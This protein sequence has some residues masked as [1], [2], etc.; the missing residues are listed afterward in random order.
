MNG[1]ATANGTI[2]GASASSHGSGD[3]HFV[4]GAGTVSYDGY[5]NGYR[6]TLFEAGLTSTSIDA[7]TSA[8]ATERGFST[9][10]FQDSSWN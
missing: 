10:S 8:S 6:G 7:I 1:A 3:E 4:D 9:S 2:D 5:E